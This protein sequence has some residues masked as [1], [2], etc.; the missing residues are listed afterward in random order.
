[1][2]FYM[3]TSLLIA[4]KNLGFLI[5]GE[6]APLMLFLVGTAFVFSGTVFAYLEVRIS[7]R[8]VQLEVE[9]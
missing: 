3:L 1:M 8:V 2:I 7:Y 5:K 6:V 9:D 4:L